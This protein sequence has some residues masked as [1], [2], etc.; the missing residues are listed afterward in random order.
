MSKSI[1]ALSG[2]VLAT[3]SLA[4]GA[5]ALAQSSSSTTAG[6]DMNANGTWYAP[7][8][9]RYLGLNAGRTDYP[10]SHKGDAYSLYMGGMWS[11]NW[12]MEFGATNFGSDSGNDAYGFNLSAVARLPL[13]P[14]F[15]VFGPP[16]AV[17]PH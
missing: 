10:G 15:S 3:A 16:A 2:I 7:A 17:Q 8:G 14:A 5:N 11:P 4:M 13:T 6:N 12:G 9:G 1:R